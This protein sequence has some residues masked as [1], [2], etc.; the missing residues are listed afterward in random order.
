MAPI[1]ELWDDIT[2]PYMKHRK[3]SSENPSDNPFALEQAIGYIKFREL[4]DLEVTFL[5]VDLT[6]ELTLK[7]PFS[8]VQDIWDESATKL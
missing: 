5:F 8:V 6:P 7:T 3:P 1:W 2:C 4:R